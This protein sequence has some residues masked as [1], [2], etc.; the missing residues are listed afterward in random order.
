VLAAYANRRYLGVDDLISNL[1]L[2]N[3]LQ[4]VQSIVQKDYLTEPCL[5]VWERVKQ[6][7]LLYDGQTIIAL[8]S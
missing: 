3:Q 7:V 5:P 1:P 2:N 6:Y 8:S 4:H